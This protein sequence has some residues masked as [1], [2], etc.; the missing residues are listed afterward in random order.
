MDEQRVPRIGAFTED[1]K[2]IWEQWICDCGTRLTDTP[3]APASMMAMPVAIADR[4]AKVHA[5]VCAHQWNA[6]GKVCE[7]HEGAAP[8]PLPDGYKVLVNPCV[9]GHEQ[10]KAEVLAVL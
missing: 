3:E 5:V 2:S 6:H 10:P 4:N 8:E 1:G 7:G 9:E